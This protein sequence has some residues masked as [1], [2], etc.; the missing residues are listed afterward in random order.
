MRRIKTARSTALAMFGWVVL[1]FWN[2]ILAKL[3]WFL[4]ANPLVGALN[5]GR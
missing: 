2:R 4:K 1:F 5:P 3:T